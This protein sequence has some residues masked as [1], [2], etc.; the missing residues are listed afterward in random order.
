MKKLEEKDISKKQRVF[1]VD[2][3]SI[4][5]EGLSEL[6]NREED[7]MVCGEAANI[8]TALKSIEY[9]SP[10]IVLVDLIL[11]DGT[12][13]RLIENLLYSRED[14]KIL[15]LSMH[16]EFVYAERCIKAGARGY[17]MKHQ[18]SEVLISAIRKVLAGDIYVSEKMGKCLLNKLALSKTEISGPSIESLSNREMEIYQMIGEGLRKQEI[19]DKLNL[20]PR[21]IETY[22]E[23]IK[24]KMNLKDFHGVMLHAIKN[25]ISI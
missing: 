14:I 16:D 6:I 12:G 15:V 5:R 22:I 2:D 9:C 20:S 18:P 13:I 7:L 23:H 10:D 24:K 17:I 3:H 25:A 1:I 8:L 19:A 21:T 4:V 11:E